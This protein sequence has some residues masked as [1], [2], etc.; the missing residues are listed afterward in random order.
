[1]KSLGIRAGSIEIIYYYNDMLA[2][3]CT[4]PDWRAIDNNVPTCFY[5]VFLIFIFL[6][7]TV[8]HTSSIRSLYDDGS[9]IFERFLRRFLDGGCSRLPTL[10]ASVHDKNKSLVVDGVRPPALR[11]VTR[12]T[13][14]TLIGTFAHCLLRNR[15]L[16]IN[17]RII[18]IIIT[19][20]S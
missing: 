8:E 14:I 4:Q 20:K 15:V 19:A 12:Y 5:Y 11:I 3:A 13:L 9:G 17:I 16:I 18:I 7:I 2:N 1:M 10:A 6:T